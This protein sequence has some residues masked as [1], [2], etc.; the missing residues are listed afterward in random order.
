[1]GSECLVFIKYSW[2]VL[3]YFLRILRMREFGFIKRWSK[4][5]LHHPV[6]C[7][8]TIRFYGVRIES[9]R[10][11]AICYGVVFAIS[12]IVYVWELVMVRRSNKFPYLP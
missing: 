11:T 9:I 5:Y 7:E 4:V 3:L 12:F 8:P 6:Y 1:M 10:P 2:N